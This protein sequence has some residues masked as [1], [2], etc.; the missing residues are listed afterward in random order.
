M[1]DLVRY[2]PR[3]PRG[4]PALSSSVHLLVHEVRAGPLLMCQYVDLLV[5][6]GPLHQ[7]YVLD[8]AVP[9]VSERKNVSDKNTFQETNA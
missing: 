3:S 4:A 2:P 9:A 6:L 8:H 5:A 7:L 1:K